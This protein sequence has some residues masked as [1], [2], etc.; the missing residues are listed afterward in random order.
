MERN[1][2]HDVYDKLAMKYGMSREQ[3]IKACEDM[4]RQAESVGLEYHFDSLVLT[5]TFDA[6]RLTHFAAGR[7][8]MAEMTELLYRAYFTE[9]KHI[10]DR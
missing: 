7:G 4:K 1:V 5:N 8:K 2:E 9:S 10:G 6:H 3:A